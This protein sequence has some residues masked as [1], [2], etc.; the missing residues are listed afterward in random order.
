MV[1]HA[2]CIGSMNSNFLPE[3]LI[4]SFCR[5]RACWPVIV[6]TT[7]QELGAAFLTS[8]LLE[9]LT[10]WMRERS[11]ARAPLTKVYHCP[12]IRKHGIG[13]YRRASVRKP[14]PGNVLRPN[15]V[16]FGHHGPV[17][18]CRQAHGYQCAEPRALAFA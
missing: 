13:D 4:L 9:S 18:I 17:L 1:D 5:P 10:I 2:I 6:V 14:N 7:R 3:F 11:R 15:G 16:Q 8:R 12:T